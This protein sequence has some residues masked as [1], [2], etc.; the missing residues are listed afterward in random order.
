MKVTYD[1]AAE[2]MY[3]YFTEISPGGVAQTEAFQ[4]SAVDLDAAGDII[5]LQVYGSENLRLANRLYYALQ[6]VEVLY[7]ENNESLRVSFS[8]SGIVS[9]TVDWDANID[10]DQDGQILGLEILFGGE[11]TANNRL[12]YVS[13]YTH[14]E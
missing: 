13:P 9:R 6:H 4:K 14:P 11:L 5:A 3:V 12:R 7:D 8:Q 2:A 1:D 10:L